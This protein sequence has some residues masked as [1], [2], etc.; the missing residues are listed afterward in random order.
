MLPWEK[1]PNIFAN[2][3]PQGP[4]PSLWLD[5]QRYPDDKHIYFGYGPL[6]VT[7]TT[8]II[9]FLVGNP[10]KPSFATV[11]GWGVDPTY[12][13]YRYVPQG[14]QI[15][16]INHSQAQKL[17]WLNHF[18]WIQNWLVVSTH[19]KNISQNGNLPQIGVKIK[20]IWNHHP[21]NQEMSKKIK[22]WAFFCRK[23]WLVLVGNQWRQV[24]FPQVKLK[25]N[26]DNLVGFPERCGSPRVLYL[27]WTPLVVAFRCWK[28]NF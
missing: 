28:G 21:E 25:T 16:V 11:T 7:V 2:H 24:Y 8:R 5:V 22:D 12:T 4:W 17:G 19:L 18:Q 27:G 14:P 6:T 15:T 13:V 26:N 3:I 1:F 20:N 23:T 10:Y 9:T